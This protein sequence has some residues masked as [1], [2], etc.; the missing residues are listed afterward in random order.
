M[1]DD[2][3]LIAKMKVD[4]KQ[5]FTTRRLDMGCCDVSLELASKEAVD[6][7]V[8]LDDA[9]RMPSDRSLLS[10]SGPSLEGYE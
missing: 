2:A 1:I 4:Q 7:D 10:I 8:L 6:G 3:K 5:D 9:I